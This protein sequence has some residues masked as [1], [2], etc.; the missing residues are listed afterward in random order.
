MKILLVDDTELV[1][2]PIEIKLKRAGHAVFSASN[3]AQALDAFKHNPVDLI[4]T[5][6]RM[7]E[8]DG[9]ELLRR[10]KALKPSQDLIIITG[11]AELESSVEALRLGAANYLMKPI[12]LDELMLAVNRIEK[13]QTRERQIKEREERV[14]R[15]RKMAELGSVAAGVAHEI[16]NPNTFIRGNV[17]TLMRL[18]PKLETFLQSAVEAGVDAPDILN[19]IRL[20]VPDI[21]GA[22][23][24]G[25]SRITKI[26]DGMAAFTR[27]ETP[28][29]M[30]PLDLNRC[31][32]QALHI[33]SQHFEISK[34]QWS[35]QSH[36]P[37]VRGRT[38]NMVDLV[39]ELLK[40]SFKAVQD[41][42]DG[43]VRI[44]ITQPDPNTVRL[45][46]TDN[47]VGIPPQEQE[48]VFTPFYTNHPE[49]GTPGLGLS[50]VYAE[51]R[52]FGGDVSIESQAGQGTAVMVTLPAHKEG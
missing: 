47:G 3:G 50:R 8:M 28:Q 31:I 46:I 11:Y 4:I 33:L 45:A 29:E 48:K 44:T 23:L 24:D 40:N 34:I 37:H 41:R 6:I 43:S 18:W 25:T 22:M 27:S 42:P 36:L 51:A 10:V 17:Q 49:I 19:F 21:L 16:N 35:P 14:A 26:V 15:A 38:E 30:M 20:E 1:R 52:R 32:D 12:R 7:P 13:Q 39:V 5:D 2:G 9:L